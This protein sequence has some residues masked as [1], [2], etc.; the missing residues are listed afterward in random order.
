M[1]PIFTSKVEQILLGTDSVT[2]SSRHSRVI[3]LGAILAALRRS[4]L[5]IFL[6]TSSF[7]SLLYELAIT[8]R[9]PATNIIFIVHLFRSQGK[10]VSHRI[11]PEFSLADRPYTEATFL[12]PIFHSTS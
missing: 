12:F 7:Q 8:L 4:A 11:A 3:V 5:L 6:S 10:I 2:F 1:S 9:P